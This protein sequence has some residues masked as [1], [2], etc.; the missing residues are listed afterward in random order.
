MNVENLV[1][2]RGWGLDVR[3]DTRFCCD[4]GINLRSVACKRC[5]AMTDDDQ[6]GQ[7]MS[8]WSH[9]EVSETLNL[10]KHHAQRGSA[11]DEE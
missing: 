5:E 6:T 2:G 9:L 8:I 7:A 4:A 1:R 11:E 3:L 10:I